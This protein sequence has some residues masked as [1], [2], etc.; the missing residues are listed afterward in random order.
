MSFLTIKYSY[1]LD[2]LLE[3]LNI[4]SV[5]TPKK[6]VVAAIIIYIL[7]LLPFIIII[8]KALSL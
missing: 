8:G 1:E 6:D 7:M 5:K 3:D 4:K 2:S